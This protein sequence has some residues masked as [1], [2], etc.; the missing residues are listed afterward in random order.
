MPRRV[1]TWAHPLACPVSSSGRPP[2][3]PVQPLLV[4]EVTPSSADAPFTISL[5][6]DTFD[7]F[8]EDS[9]DDDPLRIPVS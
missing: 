7:D 2:A 9:D 6:S 5:T 3:D 1:E 8:D 4:A